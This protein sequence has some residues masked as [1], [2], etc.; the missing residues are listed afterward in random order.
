MK[1]LK[2][3]FDFCLRRWK[4]FNETTEEEEEEK[5]FLKVEFKK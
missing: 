5:R 1:E 4:T 2:K 3:I